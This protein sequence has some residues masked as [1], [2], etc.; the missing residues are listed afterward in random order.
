M[1]DKKSIGHAYNIDFLNVVFAASSLFLFFSTVWMVWDDYAR[2]WKEYQR[3]FVQLETEVTQVNLAVAQGQVDQAQVDQLQTQRTQAEQELAGNQGEV[4][5]LEAQVAEIAAELFVT[6][7]AYQFTKAE[8]DAD[9]YAFEELQD[10]DPE[11]AADMRPEIDAMFQHWLE[12]GLEVE[13]LTAQRDEARDEIREFTS[14]IGE[15]DAQLT[16][17]TAE[18]SR[19]SNQLD[20]PGTER[21]QRLPTERPVARL[22]GADHHGAAGDHADHRGRCEFHAGREDGPLRHVPPRDRS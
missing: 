20:A 10:S 6:N 5:A 22:H 9:R 12:L 13:A 8:Y 2:E 16:E 14:R 17:L 3:R 18:T 11:E 1:A 15:I 19:L 4:D 7:Q 21:R